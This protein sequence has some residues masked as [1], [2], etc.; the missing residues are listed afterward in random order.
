VSDTLPVNEALIRLVIFAGVFACIASWEFFAPRRITQFSRRERWPAN[1][2]LALTNVLVV[3]ILTPTATVGIAIWVNAQHWGLLNQLTLPTGVEIV[4]SVML[5]DMLIYFQHR[6]FHVLPFF[7]KFHRMHHTD[8]EFDTTTA[9]R[10]HPIEI[11]ISVLIKTLMVLILGPPILAVLYFE[12][13]L[14]ATAMFNHGNIRV[15]LALDRILRT[16]LVTPDMHRVHHSVVGKETNS[17]YGFNL[18]WWDKLFNT[19]RAQP[20][21]GHVDM[22]IGLS[23]FPEAKELG[24]LRMLAQPFQKAQPQVED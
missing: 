8:L 2:G 16:V 11:A 24:Y 22:Q 1:L 23:Q 21:A 15:P 14:N 3:R 12:I 18:P 13:L 9:L 7:W 6:L 4:L 5:L 19:Y 10:F 17:N 20:E